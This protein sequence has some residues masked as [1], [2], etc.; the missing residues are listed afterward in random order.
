[1]VAPLRS[2]AFFLPPRRPASAPVKAGR[3]GGRKNV[4]ETDNGP[5]VPHG[6]SHLIF[7]PLL[8]RKEGGRGMGLTIARQLVESHGGN[9]YL[10]LDGRRRGANFRIT[11]P[12]KRARATIYDTR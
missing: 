3:R 7:N 10:I 5:G 4:G 6:I 11:L 2:T 9:I 8:T 1:M 12:R